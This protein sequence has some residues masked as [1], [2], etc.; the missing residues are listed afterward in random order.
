MSNEIIKDTVKA[1]AR[2]LVDQLSPHWK[3]ISKATLEESPSKGTPRPEFHT[4]GSFLYVAYENKKVLYVGESS[5]S[6]KRRLL[7]DGTGAHN[8]K[9]WYERVT[10][11]CYARFSHD[12][13]PEPYRKMLE[14]ALTIILEPEFY[15]R[16]AKAEAADE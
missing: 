15:G 8:K 1:A 5:I 3:S 9:G 6:V 10:H 2:N 4:K 13:L 14:Q 7:H 16:S 12:E 11:V